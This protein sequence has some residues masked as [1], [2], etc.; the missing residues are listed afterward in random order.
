MSIL[1]YFGWKRKDTLSLPD[2]KGPL[3]KE[4]L[5]AIIIEANKEVLKVL[6]DTQRT[7]R[8]KCIK[9]APDCK[10]KFAKYELENGTCAA[11]RKYSSQLKEKLTESLDRSWVTKFKQE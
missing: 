7:K 6:N 3:S 10:A 8:D 5:P 4:I 9:V 1:K 11:A 2:P